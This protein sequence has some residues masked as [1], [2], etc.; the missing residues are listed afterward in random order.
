MPIKIK[1]GDVATQAEE[2]KP[3]Q[4]QIPLKITK[5]LEGNLLIADHK[6]LDIVVVPSKNKILTMPKADAEKDVFDYQM[7]FADSMFLGGISTDKAP[8]GGSSF[9]IVEVT[10]PV[11][12]SVNSLQ[13]VLYQISKFIKETSEDTAIAE[14]YD[15]NIEDRFT[16]P[17][18]KESTEYGEVPPYEDTPEGKADYYPAYVYSG[19]GYM[20]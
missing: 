7:Q 20:Y 10:Y 6:Y 8:K 1:I 17:D 12:E 3:V 13:S 2:K 14:E 5:S 18:E 15:E 9:G 4:A 16:N 11:S 19:Q